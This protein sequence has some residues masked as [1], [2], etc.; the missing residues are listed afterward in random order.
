MRAA[1]FFTKSMARGRLCK[2]WTL[3]YA[4]VLMGL[5]WM[6]LGQA[7]AG[8]QER[9]EVTE[10]A[11]NVFV[12]A[13]SSGNVVASVGAD[14]AL[15]VG[16]PSA[17]STAQISSMLAKRTKSNARYVVV[18]PSSQTEGDAGWGQ[19]G[20]FVAMQENA[21]DRLGGHAMG[22]P[23][24]LPPRLVELGVDRPR[25]AFSEVLT[26]DING[27]AI[28]IVHQAPGYSNADA[29]THFHVAKLVYLGEVF[30]GDGYPEID[31]SQGGKLDGLVKQL[32]WTNPGI[33]IVPARGKVTTGADVKAFRDMIL[34]ARDR[35]QQMITAGRTEDQVVAEH[36]T[37]DFDERWGHGRVRPEA[38]VHEIYGALKGQ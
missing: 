26:F 4:L 15:L 2:R 14:G 32:G 23:R 31:S 20:A 12:F 38:F 18:Y 29:V 19:R 6:V 17:A 1:E 16:T 37:R 8:T 5:P 21:L 36:P 30:P 11:A 13:T 35:V 7:A 9:V 24:P 27:E 22:P 28:H 34:T 33:Q 3:V 25:M 10:I